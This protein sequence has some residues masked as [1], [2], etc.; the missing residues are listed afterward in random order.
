MSKARIALVVAALLLLSA[1]RGIVGGGF[2]VPFTSFGV[3]AE[4]SVDLDPA[5]PSKVN[6]GVTSSSSSK[7]E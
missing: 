7:E 1:C 6:A 3:D 2:D 4:T 5:G